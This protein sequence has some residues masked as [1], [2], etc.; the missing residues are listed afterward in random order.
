MGNV[1]ARPYRKELSANT[2][3][4]AKSCHLYNT[5]KNLPLGEFL[6]SK[7]NCSYQEDFDEEQR[8]VCAGSRTHSYPEWTEPEI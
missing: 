1:V 5:I 4:H 6:L 7:H 3:L 8:K 2:I